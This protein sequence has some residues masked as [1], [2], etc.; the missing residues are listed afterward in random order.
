MKKEEPKNIFDVI[1]LENCD[2]IPWEA[3]N[4]Y[5]YDDIIRD[6]INSF[7]RPLIYD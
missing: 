2:E 6:T 5:I 7:A 4:N 3:H 1:K